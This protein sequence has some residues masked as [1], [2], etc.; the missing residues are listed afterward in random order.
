MEGGGSSGRRECW[1]ETGG[2]PPSSSQ[3]PPQRPLMSKGGERRLAGAKRRRTHCWPRCNPLRPLS[4]LF[5]SLSLPLHSTS[6]GAMMYHMDPA[7]VE[8]LVSCTYELGGGVTERRKQEAGVKEGREEKRAAKAGS[9][10]Q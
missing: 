9:S 6:P 8:T 4:S 2:P 1:N 7:A 3:W 10:P 5:L